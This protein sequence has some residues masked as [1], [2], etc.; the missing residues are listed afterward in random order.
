M[1]KVFFTSQSLIENSTVANSMKSG[2]NIDSVSVFG[3]FSGSKINAFPSAVSYSRRMLLMA[4]LEKS[5][6]PLTIDADW[7]RQLDVLFR[8][9]KASRK[10]MKNHISSVDEEAL[11]TFLSASFEGMLRN[12][13][14]GLQDC[15]KCFVEIASITPSRVI[16]RIAGRALEL[17][18]SIKSNNV[19]TRFLAGQAFGILAPHPTNTEKS[20]HDAIQSLLVDIKPWPSAIGADANKVHGSI[21]ALGYI[22]S[23]N[24]FY[25]RVQSTTNAVVQGAVALL[26]EI[27]SSAKDTS[28]KEAVL[29]AV[30]QISGKSVV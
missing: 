18:P 14:N 10:A 17:L 15:G 6:T 25:G 20:V 16:G 27:L 29:N 5:E 21:L 8:S 2:M 28:I 12:D 1:V 24:S 13:G 26:L 30:G 11:Y 3:N 23:R 4:A 19:A 22:L 7:E 9:D